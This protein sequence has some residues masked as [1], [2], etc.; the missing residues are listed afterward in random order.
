MSPHN[1]AVEA[2]IHELLSDA[3]V[4]E[5]AHQD[6]IDEFRAGHFTEQ[7]AKEHIERSR[8]EKPH[9]WVI[10]G[11]DD[12][13]LYVEAFGPNPNYTSQSRVVKL[14]GEV[15]AAEIAARFGTTLGGTKG[16]TIPADIKTTT[17]VDADASKAPTNPWSAHPANLDARGNYN[18]SAT[19]AQRKLVQGIGV[20]KAAQIAFS[21]NGAKLGDIRPNQRRR[22]A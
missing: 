22:A 11:A 13:Q 3:G 7:S 14:V 17:A 12:N 8:T 5:V 4:L 2:R 10:A 19:T 1:Y 6:F 18:G 20:E 16:G 15:R 9:R 21:A